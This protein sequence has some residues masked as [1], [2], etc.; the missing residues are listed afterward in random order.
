M[1]SLSALQDAFQA[2]ILGQPSDI[3]QRLDG[4]GGAE[5]TVRLD[6][7]RE[8]YR[9]RLAEILAHNHPK[10][11]RL[12]GAED[13]ARA[14]GGFIDAHPSRCRNA[15][16]YGADFADF[17]GTAAPWSGQPVLSELARFEWLLGEVFDAA[18]AD[19]LAPSAMA[20]LAPG[21]WGETAFRL[22]PSLR[23]LDLAT[24]AAG[25][26]Q[27]LEEGERPG[28]VDWPVGGEPRPWIVWRRQDELLTYFRSLEPDEAAALEIAADGADFAGICEALARWHGAEA[29]PGRAAGILAQWFHDGLVTGLTRAG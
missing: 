20:A 18:D 24:D 28:P 13:F 7:Y 10:L 27:R 8:G 15:R 6:V 26:W 23:R 9:L 3:G 17:L 12:L 11:A 16:W 25:L 4:R 21:D 1:N 19:P 14:A 29:A 2:Y 22:H 5:A